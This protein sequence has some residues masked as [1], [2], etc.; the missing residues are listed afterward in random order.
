MNPKLLIIANDETTIYNF[1]R[2]IIKAFSLKGYI[3]VVCYPEGSH[4]SEIEICGCKFE[5]IQVSR[6][7]K[8]PLKDLAFMSACK[9]L[10]KRHKPD[11]VL[12]YTVKPNIYAS[13][14]CQQMHVPYIN[15]VTGLGSILQSD[16]ILAKVILFLQKTAFRKS[17][18]VFFQN[19][20][21][22]QLMLEKGV[23]KNS[24]NVQILPG[25]GVNLE[26][27]CFV[28]IRKDDGVVRFIIVS[29]IRED[30]GYNEFFEAAEQLKT[31]YT[32]IEFHVVGWYEEDY[33]KTRVDDLANRGI[34]IYHGKQDQSAVHKLV[35]NCDCSVLP[36]YHE[37]MANVLLEAASCGRPVI[38][39]KV[40]GCIET[41]ED[42]VTG[43]GCEVKSVVSLACAMEK[44]I[45]MPYSDRVEMGKLGRIKMEKEFD[46][47]I[48]ANKYIAQIEKVI[49]GSN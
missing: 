2:E 7:G 5:N 36:S 40:P 34:I 24:N 9:Q 10:I 32:N 22:C 27:H 12:T 28:P 33:Y 35:A 47:N 21:N 15:N 39:S 37:G 4:T 30:K 6:R 3:V 31:K 11:I 1:R 13:F 14:A 38:A 44:F 29:R 48:V 25:S 23:V 49:G 19:K 16:S 20:S 45:Q 18:C 43:I 46:R 41:F 26:L 8:N 42:G 17:S